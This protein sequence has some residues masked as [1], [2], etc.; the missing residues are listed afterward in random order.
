MSRSS[1]VISRHQKSVAPSTNAIPFVYARA[2]GCW[3]WNPEGRKFLDFAAGIA[4]HNVGHANPEVVRAIAGQLKSGT[5]AAFTD[6]YAEEP[7][8]FAEEILHACP[9]HLR[10]GKVFFTNSGAENVEAAQKCA[11]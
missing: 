9:G 6:F 11:K 10:G 7:V 5:H 1:S 8:A 3:V 4:V 2:K